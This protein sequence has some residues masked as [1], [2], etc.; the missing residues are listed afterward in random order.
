MTLNQTT[1]A[2]TLVPLTMGQILD[3]AFRVYR[4]Q[5]LL[6][7]GIVAAFQAPMAIGQLIQGLVFN[8]FNQ[9]FDATTAAP[10]QG[11]ETM[12]ALLLAGSLVGN[13][14]TLVTAVLTQFG[15]AALALI[16]A[17][18]YLGDPLPF[19]ELVRLIRENFWQIVLAIIGI[20]VI[21]IMITLFAIVVPILGWF[22][23]WGILLFY[24]IAVIPLVTPVV[25]LEKRQAFDAFRRVWDLVRQ[26]FW[27]VLAFGGVL[28]FMAGML[29]AGPAL[30]AAGGAQLLL[31]DGGQPSIWVNVVTTM[32]GLAVGVIF[33][34]IQIAAMV[35][36]YLDL[37]VR[38]EGFDLTVQAEKV[39]GTSVEIVGMLARVPAG[40]KPQFITRN[41]WLY[42]VGLNVGFLLFLAAVIGIMVLIFAA[43]ANTLLGSGSF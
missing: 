8:Q 31:S 14:F 18:S 3:R 2:K 17:H 1:T 20:I 21:N 39:D 27:W 24:S 6:L 22:T 36:M 23:G 33:I 26:R 28:F 35:I 19:A 12:F 30:L 9:S 5:F 37:R 25:V 40:F 43:I 42:F 10:G 34:P 29:T 15:Y 32:V 41:E 11:F 7:L 16:I 13:L 4:Q 38:F